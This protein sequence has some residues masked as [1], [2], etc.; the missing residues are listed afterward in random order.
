MTTFSIRSPSAG[1]PLGV[2]GLMTAY[3]AGNVTLANAVGTGIAD[4]K[5]VYS[6]M[7]EIIKFYLGAE[8]I[9]KN[10][11]TWR[12][13]EPEHLA[14]VLDHL[15]ELVVKEVRVGRLRDAGRTQS[16]QGRPSRLP[17]Q[18]QSEPEELRRPAHACAVDLPYLRG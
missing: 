9:L 3:Q 6:Y 4:D 15:E 2:P 14:Y 12:C 10:V 1:F 16:R 8:P 11:P 17:R 5:A 18:V 7:P 13:R